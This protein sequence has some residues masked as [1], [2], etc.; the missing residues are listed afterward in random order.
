MSANHGG[1]LC[2]LS[3]GHRNG[4]EEKKKIRGAG[5]W[6][7]G[8]GR[9][10]NGIDLHRGIGPNTWNRGV[11]VVRSKQRSNASRYR[12]ARSPPS[13][14]AV[15]AKPAPQP[16]RRSRGVSGHKRSPPLV[17]GEPRRA[18]QYMGEKA[19]LG[20]MIG[21]NEPMR[22]VE[23]EE[24]W[25][26][27]ACCVAAAHGPRI[28]HTQTKHKEGKK[29]TCTRF[30]VLSTF[31]ENRRVV[32]DLR[33]VVH[34]ARLTDSVAGRRQRPVRQREALRVRV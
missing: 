14:F 29:K 1:T 6:A 30:A 19:T 25:G 34:E 26:G 23:E 5:R 11:F 21:G 10:G 4:G 2:M 7:G 15:F 27:G 28:W 20:R 17:R 22:T 8:E 12:Q 3:F 24:R 9:R 31:W 13:P 33:V 32:R 16:T 18:R